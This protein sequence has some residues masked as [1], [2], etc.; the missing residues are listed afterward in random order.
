MKLAIMQPYIFPYIGYFQLI[1]EVEKFVIYDDVAFIKKGWINRN[2]I[3]TNKRKYTFTIPIK[4]ISQNALIKD[5]KLMITEK[6]KKKFLKTIEHS[7]SKAINFE[8]VFPIIEKTIKPNTKFLVDLHLISLYL[9]IKYLNLNTTIIQS[10]LK[11]NNRLIK[12]QNRIL[13]ICFNERANF[14]I[15]LSGGMKLYDKELFIKNGIDLKFLK[16]EKVKYSQFKNNFVSSLSI[17]DILMFNDLN[18]ICHFLNSYR[19]I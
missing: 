5:I 12:G 6:W 18:E 2:Q 7:Y 10:S 4:N 15:N 11:Y 3:L 14:Y 13:D 19:L 8:K 16:T 1:N 9:I 17:I